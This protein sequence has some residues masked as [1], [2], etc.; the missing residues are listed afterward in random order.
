MM[1]YIVIIFL[2]RLLTF[3]YLIVYFCIFNKNQQ[4]E[5]TFKTKIDDEP[6]KANLLTSLQSLVDARNDFAHGGIP[7]SLSG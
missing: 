3:Q 5:K 4:V 7:S 6:S 1:K 2:T